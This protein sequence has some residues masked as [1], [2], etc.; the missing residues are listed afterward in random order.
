VSGVSLRDEKGRVTETTWKLAKPEEME[1]KVPLQTATAGTVT[2]LIHKLG[3]RQPNEIP[4]HT[5]A[6]AGR[7]DAFAIHAGDANGM[8]KGT[9]LD[10]VTSLE[11]DGLHFVPG[12]LSRAN[13]VDELKLM[14]SDAGAGSRLQAGESITVHVG[15]KD[16]RSSDLK[17]AVEAPRPRVTMLGKSMHPDTADSPAT[18]RLDNPDELPQDARLSFFLKTQVP[19]NFPSNEKIEVATA[20]ESFKVL[21]SEND[22]NLTPQDS[23]TILGVL[24]PM[25][26]LGPSAFGPLKFRPVTVDGIDG[27]WQPLITLVRMPVLQSVRCEKVPEKECTLSGDKLFLINAVSSDPDFSNSVTVPDGFVEAVLRIPS[28]KGTT[29]YLKLRDDPSKVVTATVPMLSAQ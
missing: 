1:V 22:G 11:V 14:T 27:D 19:E 8:L 29:L 18:V 7:L 21:L 20:D 26:L 3:S 4:L 13:Q 9:R 16:G 25:K 6:E 5:Y 24:D 10:Q 12:A 2:L 15:L 23:K 28:P 17:T